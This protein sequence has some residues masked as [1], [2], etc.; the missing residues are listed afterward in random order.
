MTL[1]EQAFLLMRAE[2]LKNHLQQI[3]YVMK[4]EC[5]KIWKWG[6]HLG[7]SKGC[8][9]VLTGRWAISPGSGLLRCCMRIG[10]LY[11]EA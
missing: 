11:Q 7:G 1:V 6:S 4:E 9:G 5:G 8:D 2:K 10:A 3:A